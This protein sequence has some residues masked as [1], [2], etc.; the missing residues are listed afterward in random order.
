M[1][2]HEKTYEPENNSKRGEK[3]RSELLT[4]KEAAEFLN[5][6]YSYFRQCRNKGYFGRDKYGAPEFINFSANN[7]KGIRYRKETLKTWIENYPRHKTPAEYFDVSY[8]E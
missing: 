6:N 4:T 7:E 1:E 2:T 8:D 3:Y 5:I